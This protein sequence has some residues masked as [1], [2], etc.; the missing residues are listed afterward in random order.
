MIILKT[1]HEMELIRKACEITA[2]CYEAV[3]QAI[4]PGISTY[5]IDQIVYHHIKRLDAV[6]GFLHY[7]DPPFPGSACIS[8]N[9]EVVHGIPSRDRI[10]EDGDI[11]SV[12]LGAKYR[13]YNGDSAR[14]YPVGQVRA[15]WLQ[16]IDVAEKAFWEGV[17]QVKKGCRLG[18]ISHAVQVYVEKHGFG[19]IRELTGHGIGADLHEDPNLLNYGRAGRGSRLEPGMVLCLEP[20]ITEG[21]YRIEMLEDEWTIATRDGKAA[22][23]YENTFAI[24]EQGLEILTLTEKDRIKYKD[25]LAQIEKQGWN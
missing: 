14:T 12:D 19:V 5:E 23:H 2:S 20:M 8:I 22:A 25:L 16:L 1:E 11:V 4:K 9:D 3:E 17:K 6:P 13:G 18:D 10:L 15:K 24:T 21:S 7:G